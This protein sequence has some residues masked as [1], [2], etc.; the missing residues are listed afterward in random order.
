MKI[1]LSLLL[2]FLLTIA[3]KRDNNLELE[4][5]KEATIY[6]DNNNLKLF[7]RM[8]KE[9]AD[10]GSRQK[11]VAFL[12]SLKAL[13]S[14]RIN[15]KS[16]S[17]NLKS[18]KTS[19]YTFVNDT[20]KAS[21]KNEFKLKDVQ[22]QNDSSSFLIYY[23]DILLFEKDLLELA[24]INLSGSC[25]WYSSYLPVNKSKD[26][27]SVN[28]EYSIAA[29]PDFYFPRSIEIEPDSISIYKM[30]EKITVPFITEVVGGILLLRFRPNAS[31]KYVI[32]GGVKIKSLYNE[33]YKSHRF[34]DSVF[35]K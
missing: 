18:Y 26:T 16:S 6:L 4:V 30:G 1:S 22:V 12:N 8:E 25:T 13:L 17:E 35:V 3:C 24:L 31:G 23:Q 11:E 5:L 2:F 27:V 21:P 7:K 29:M 10:N 28:E 33:F 20:L 32:K 14:K 15:A 9:V 19:I 34:R